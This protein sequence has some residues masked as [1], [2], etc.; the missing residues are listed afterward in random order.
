M[1]FLFIGISSKRIFSSLF[2]RRRGD[3][4]VRYTIKRILWLIPVI[5]AVS[6]IVFTLIELAPGTVVDGMIAGDMTPEDVAALRKMYDL[7]KPMLYRYGKYMLN[8][9]Q[10]NLGLSQSTGLS[11]F[12]MYISRLPATLLLSFSAAIIGIVVAIPMGIR[13]ARRAGTITD[14]ATT[15][16]SLI[17]MSMPAFWLGLLLM[18]LFSMWLGWLPAGGNK[19]GILSLILP[20]V[21]SA[22]A[23]MATCTRQ[24]R[25]SMLEVLKADFMRT[26]RAKGVSEE[27]VIRKHA[28]GNAMIP[29]ITV[30]G[31]SICIQLA[32]SVVIEQ[33]F[34]WPGVGRM[35]IEGV[36]QRDVTIILGCVIMTT[37][38]YVIVMLIVDLAYAYVDPRIKSQYI[39]K[40]R[41]QKSIVR[42]LPN[43]ATPDLS[44]AI[45]DSDK[46]FSAASDDDGGMA[47]AEQSHEDITGISAALTSNS[48]GYFW[49]TET[50]DTSDTSY[51]GASD[52]VTKSDEDIAFGGTTDNA[53]A[54]VVKERYKKRSQMG[55]IWHRLTRSKSAIVGIVILGFVFLLAIISLFMSYDGIIAANVPARFSPPSWKFPFGTDSMGRNA[56]LRVI[57]GTRYSIV[58]GFGAVAMSAVFGV[59]LGS[60]AAYYGGKVDNIIMRVNDILA[61]IPG[62][63]LGIVI[64]VMLGMKLQN[65]IIAVSVAG[66]PHFIRM[67]RAS[68]LTV[69]DNEYVEAAR[70]M[71]FSDLRI[72]FTQILPNGLSPIIVQATSSLGATIM[73]AASLSYLGFGVPSPTPEWGA[74]VSAGRD[75]IRTAPWL[76][77]FPGVAMMITVLGFNLLGDGLRDALDPKLKK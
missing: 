26:A 19:D 38:L 42:I 68:I 66:I 39:G 11:V 47:D 23:L 76:M 53:S 13:A 5:L 8:L 70:A 41:K 2:D 43:P 10:G 58:I 17:G 15:T 21:C 3:L 32:G 45:T 60:I 75:F 25:S 37:I 67:A 22:M 1:R 27:T 12:D 74:L 29:I 7:D 24:T 36:F 20:A 64:M 56:F 14:T 77:A 30:I 62:L 54:V 71:G 51:N 6:F 55:E 4:L 9:V 49:E 57:Y 28:L 50:S 73:I 52:Y 16:F 63:L 35:L 61:S 69:K 46:V 65:L 44:P 48:C 31:T 72:I 40:K 59:T 34:A 18:L 33:V